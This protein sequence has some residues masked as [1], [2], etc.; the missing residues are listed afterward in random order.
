MAKFTQV[1]EREWIHENVVG[2]A[3]DRCKLWYDGHGVSFSLV[4]MPPHHELSLHRHETWVAVFV[5]E[6]GLNWTSGDEERKTGP[7]D[8]YFVPPGEEHIESSVDESLVLI[9]K[10]EPNVQYPIDENGN[11]RA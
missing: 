3:I 7:G 8:F 6:G 2:H 4:K 10:A 5:I 1:D 9:I 11:R